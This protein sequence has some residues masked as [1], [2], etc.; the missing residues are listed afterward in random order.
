M[1]KLQQLLAQLAATD[2]KLDALLAHEDLTDEQRAEHD[3]L[4]AERQKTKAAIARQ[5]EKLARDEERAKLEAEAEQ[6]RR[7]AEERAGRAV[8]APGANRVTDPDPPR[9]QDVPGARAAEAVP[10]EYRR[11]GALKHFRGD[12]QGRTAEERA[13]RF[14][15]WA[16]AALAQQLPSRYRFPRAQE[17]VSRHMAAVTS[18]DATG[19]QYLIPEE[20]SQDII[21]LREQYGVARRVLRVVPML[22]DTK[23]I[24]RRQGGLTAYFVGEGGAGTESNK[25]WDQVSLTARKLMCLSRVS[26]E[27]D[28][29]LAV[30]WG[31]DLAGEIAY[32]FAEKED[33]CA[34]NGDGTS[35]YGGILGVR[36][37]LQNVDGAGADSAGLVTGTGN[38]WSEL[39]LADFD[40]TVGKLPQYADTP[41]AAWVMHRTFYYE[42]IEKLV[43]A[44]G[45]VP[46]FEVRE[47]RRGRPLFKGYPVEFS[48]V[49]PNTEANSSVVCTLG[50]HAKG[51]AFGDRGGEEVEFSDQA[52][53]GGESMWERDELGVRGK[54]RFDINVHDV[55]SSSAPGPIVGLQTAAA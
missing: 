10:A 40:R 45:G 14:G 13:Y 49:F 36:A 8:P 32:A 37:K 18:K 43:Q 52:T 7:A 55:G 48:Q 23:K 44:A 25:T 51:A 11:H 31:D 33:Q 41:A 2:E 28:E 39:V 17:Y 3:R 5:Q 20:F 12:R 46:A 35:T 9:P 53:V 24:P 42:V 54:E 19:H 50:D 34:F 29:G 1:E 30:S 22:A 15:L 21:D 6:A 38:A 47:G 26:N 16:L 27:V 4:V